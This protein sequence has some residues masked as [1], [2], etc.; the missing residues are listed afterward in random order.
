MDTSS[1]FLICWNKVYFIKEV[2]GI[3]IQ[4]TL[5]LVVHN[6]FTVMLFEF[7]LFTCNRLL[8]NFY[9]FR[10]IVSFISWI[11]SMP[12]FILPLHGKDGEWPHI[13]STHYLTTTKP[14]R[15]PA[16]L[17]LQDTPTSSISW[18]PVSCHPKGAAKFIPE[19]LWE[20][21]R[22]P[23]EW[24]ARL[25]EV[26]ADNHSCSCTNWHWVVRIIKRVQS[27]Y[28]YTFYKHQRHP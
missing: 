23:S 28:R 6:Q 20:L 3:Y 19:M 17:S 24:Y 22:T 21:W 1:L 18:W 5:C 11:S 13:R 7:C 12:F 4:N 8:T 25:P 10:F 16:Q 26:R 9:S 15:V 2:D 27:N 14:N